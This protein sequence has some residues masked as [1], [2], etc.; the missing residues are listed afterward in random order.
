MHCYLFKGAKKFRQRFEDM[1]DT[2]K[3]RALVRLPQ[4]SP[5]RKAARDLLPV[6]WRAAR[7]GVNSGGSKLVGFAATQNM[8]YLKKSK[9]GNNTSV[10]NVRVGQV[11]DQAL[12]AI[13]TT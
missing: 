11:Q 6:A 12:Q 7:T 13:S 4:F 8:A 1:K 10:S 2:V 3:M 9:Q 5:Q